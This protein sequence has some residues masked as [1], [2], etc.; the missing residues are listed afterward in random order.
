MTF[1]KIE[2]PLTPDEQD[3]E[4]AHNLYK[5]M[6][7]FRPRFINSPEAARRYLEE[8]RAALEDPGT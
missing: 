1:D 3:I 8:Y 2:Q 7:G 6:H 4:A 5:S